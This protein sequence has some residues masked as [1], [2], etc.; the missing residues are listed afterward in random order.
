MIVLTL[1]HG[2]VVESGAH[3]RG[4]KRDKAIVCGGE[5]AVNSSDQDAG[6]KWKA[7]TAGRRPLAAGFRSACRRMRVAALDVKRRPSS[8]CGVLHKRWSSGASSEASSEASSLKGTRSH[9][10]TIV[11]R[12]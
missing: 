3:G 7:R 8:V 6:G 11:G 4:A 9:R 1:S 5:Y 2:A 12:I 10:R